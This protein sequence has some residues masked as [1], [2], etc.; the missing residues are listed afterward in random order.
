MSAHLSKKPVA[1]EFAPPGHTFELPI[2]T[3]DEDIISINNVLTAL[4]NIG[5]QNEEKCAVC[6]N[7]KPIETGY[8][9]RAVLPN[10]DIFEFGLEDLLLLHSVAPARVEKIN[11]AR[12]HSAGPCEIIVKMLDSK[13]KMMT[14]STIQFAAATHK[15]KWTS[16][17]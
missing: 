7:V 15:R 6:Y 9:L 2:N 14:V 16:V 12:S 1:L 11:I 5:S 17:Q 10:T 3:P 8:L 13:Q 4:M